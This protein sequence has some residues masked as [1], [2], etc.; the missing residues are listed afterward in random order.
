MKRLLLLLAMT[1]TITSLIGQEKPIGIV[2]HG[3]AGY[4]N[5]ANLSE[6]EIE[7][8]EKKLNDALSIGYT[9]L[10]EGGTS[11]EAIVA[12]IKTLEDSPLFNAGKGSVLCN[13]EIAEMDASIM[14]GK[15]LNAGAV[16]GVQLTKNP[17]TAAQI[18]MTKSP[19]V[20]L[21]GK[22][23]DEFAKKSGLAME[24]PAY[25]ITE[26]NLERIK[27]LKSEDKSEVEPTLPIDKR[28]NGINDLKFGTVGAVALD[29]N[30]DLAAG[31]SSGGMANKKNNR[32]G[33]SPI[34][35]AG[36]YANNQSCAVSCTGHGEYF[37]RL[38]VAHEVSALMIHRRWDLDKAASYVIHQELENLGGKGGLIAMDRQGNV[39]MPFN[40][41]SMFR[42]V[43]TNQ[44]LSE[45]SIFK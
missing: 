26:Q 2:I 22:G 34:I 12:A 27:L 41:S 39:S 8:Y 40:T 42:A 15:T 35:G 1:L 18:V 36:T 5:Q 24:K 28:K 37:I 13:E 14:L 21:S 32:I 25:F 29:Q 6:A 17:I 19:H 45:V 33:D 11:E 7:A 16:A 4:M 31:T 38:A 43:K 23:A 44:G 10:L 3:G 20:I 9:I 30:G